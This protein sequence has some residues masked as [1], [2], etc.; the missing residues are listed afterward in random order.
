M[1]FPTIATDLIE[2]TVVATTPVTIKHGLGRQVGGWQV[3]WRD[4]AGIDFHVQD[5]T[6]DTSREL[7]LIPSASGNVRLVLY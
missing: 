4:T 2:L 6:L 3:L 1:I 5:S 7:V